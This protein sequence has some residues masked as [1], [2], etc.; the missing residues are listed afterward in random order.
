VKEMP[1]L[2]NQERQRRA[3]ALSVD[4]NTDSNSSDLA[5]RKQLSHPLSGS[6]LGLLGNVRVDDHALDGLAGYRT[7]NGRLDLR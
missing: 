5:A 2:A 3:E 7:T 1:F 6:T 4:S